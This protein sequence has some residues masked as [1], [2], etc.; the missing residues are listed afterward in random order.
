MDLRTKLGIGIAAVAGLFMFS[1]KASADTGAGGGAVTPVNGGVNA[2]IQTQGGAVVTTPPPTGSGG[3][4]TGMGVRY[5]WQG[6]SPWGAM[7]LG[8]STT[9][10]GSAGCLLT[11]LT[12]ARNALLSSNVTPDVANTMVQ[13]ANGFSG[14]NMILPMAAT[15]LGV[16]A[17]EVNRIRAGAGTVAQM[18]AR[19]DDTLMRGGLAIVNVDKGVPDGTGDH[20]I[21]VH[22]KTAQGYAGADPATAKDTFLNT[23]TLKGTAMWGSTPMPYVAVGVAPV[24]RA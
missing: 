7:K 23:S 18:I 19:I 3:L 20:F 5:F 17:A 4:L 14:A 10:I 9:S 2:S 22:S 1:K 21:L 12:M 11:A 16:S 8:F 13:A 6:A 24:F 15:A